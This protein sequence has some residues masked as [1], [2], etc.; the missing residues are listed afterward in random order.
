MRGLYGWHRTLL[1]SLW[2]VAGMA[3]PASFPPRAI[4]GSA[5]VAI[6]VVGDTPVA[7]AVDADTSRAFVLNQGNRGTPAPS[8][9]VSVLDTRRLQVLRTVPV[10]IAPAAVAI[11]RGTQ[12]VFVVNSGAPPLSCDGSVSILDARSG[13]KVVGDITVGNDPVA[14]AVDEALQRV[15]VL[16]RGDACAGARGT[17]SVLDARDGRLLHTIAVGSYPVRV[18]VDPQRHVA[19]IGNLRRSAM[20]AIDIAHARVTATI[21]LGIPEGTLA[22]LQLDAPRQRVLVLGYP[23]RA[24]NDGSNGTGSLTTLDARTGRL[25]N[26]VPLP[27]PLSVAVDESSGNAL[28]TTGGLVNNTRRSEVGGRVIALHEPQGNVL[29]TRQVGVSPVALRVDGPRGRVYVLNE[30]TVLAGAARGNGSVTILRA[31]S[32]RV[33]CTVS[34]GHRPA[35]VALSQR[36]A[37]AFVVNTGDNTVSTVYPPC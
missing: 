6:A 5:P 31:R 8:G 15:L 36:D 25:L 32:G 20:S 18:V 37:R 21:A 2:F 1:L 33:L 23:P 7:I 10:G 34:V 24:E 27:N 4:A 22:Q 17:L 29:Y 13:N 9:T 16:N 12:H 26:S 30:G 19:F 11:D 14:I 3:L 35:D 28:V